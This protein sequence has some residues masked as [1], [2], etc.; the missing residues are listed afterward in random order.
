[1]LPLPDARL[2]D[3]VIIGGGATG[4]GVAV[5]AASRGYATCLLEAEDFAKGTSS[6]STKLVHGGVRYLEQGNVSLVME[7]L[8]ERGILRQIAPHLVHDLPFI[9]PSYKWWESP[10]YGVGLKVYDLLAGRYGFGRSEHLS[11]DEIVRR[12]PTIERD[13]LRGGTLY[14]DGQFDDARL[15]INLAQTAIAHGAHLRNRCRV[16]GFE[17]HGEHGAISAVIAED[18]RSGTE[19]TIRGKV[20]VNATGPFTDGVRRLLDANAAP[21]IAP[22]RGVHLVF[23]R[24]LLAGDHAIMVPH[25]R[26]G[27]VLF[28]VP[29][30]HV[31]VVGTTDT[32]VKTADLEP[33]ASSEEIDFI[34]ETAEGY[35]ARRP[36]RAD[37]LS[38]FAGIRPLVELQPSGAGNTAKLSRD[39][40]IHIDPDSALITI[41]GGKWTTYR[42][43]AEDLVNHAATLGDLPE[44]PCITSS[45]HVHGYREPKATDVVGAWATRTARDA[46]GSD[47]DLLDAFERATPGL[48]EPIHP[49][50][51]IT[52]GQV[53]WAARNE[54]ATTT[55]DVLA[56]RTRAI[57]F[58]ARAAI[59]AA[60]VV[61]GILATE[62][63]HDAAWTARDAQTF[64]AIAR[65]YVA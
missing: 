40:T 23:P 18:A 26:D 46:Y 49:R 45:L 2:Y 33:R 65:G 43:M 25:T 52:K 34:L 59:E 3:L 51:P 38:V 42:R 60:P 32:P 16:V 64:A 9:V 11:A 29:W 6:R 30:H 19:L 28:A 41:A 10:F 5:D 50:L 57:L 58:D 20:F 61:A 7:A 27:R 47:A 21:M 63:G 1:M 14:H 54:L 55:D 4:L 56:R 15:A 48:R 17:R 24:E 35:L 36:T 62:L 53:V 22:S 12:I 8:H 37:I 31:V 39:H 13:G 44:K